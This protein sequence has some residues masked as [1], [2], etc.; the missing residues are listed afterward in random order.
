MKLNSK[1]RRKVDRLPE[2]MKMLMELINNECFVDEYHSGS[3]GWHVKFQIE[4]TNFTLI[5]DRGCLEIVKDN[6][7]GT[8]S[9]FSGN[10]SLQ[11][12]T[13][14]NIANEINKIFA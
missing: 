2:E 10:A 4:K 5:Y 8:H 9:I 12:H 14:T 7:G 6:N 11:K 3:V 13:I 1:Y